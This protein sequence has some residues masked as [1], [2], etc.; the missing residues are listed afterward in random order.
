METSSLTAPIVDGPTFPASTGEG[1]SQSSSTP[2]P[3]STD[4]AV[5]AVRESLRERIGGADPLTGSTGENAPGSV[6]QPRRSSRAEREALA[7]RDA[8]MIEGVQR[9][10]KSWVGIIAS[11]VSAGDVDLRYMEA[12]QEGWTA[13]VIFLEMCVAKWVG[14]DAE[15][16]EE[17][18]L[19]LGVG[20]ILTIKVLSAIER[21]RRARDAE[22][23]AGVDPRAQGRGKNNSSAVVG[24]PA[25][26]RIS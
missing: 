9:L 26:I 3:V 19:G 13:T 21:R 23:D 14:P 5:E 25:D 7:A 4:P 16:L 12:A 18:G 15:Y 2:S 20:S 11:G 24:G 8:R 6:Q 22:A 1:G 17:W 10:A